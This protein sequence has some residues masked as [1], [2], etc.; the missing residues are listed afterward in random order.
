[1][2]TAEPSAQSSDKRHQRPETHLIV[3]AADVHRNAIPDPR[4]QPPRRPDTGAARR[5]VSPR[6]AAIR[7]GGCGGGPQAPGPGSVAG[8]AGEDNQRQW[9]SLEVARVGGLQERSTRRVKSY[10][11]RLLVTQFLNDPLRITEFL[12][13]PCN[14]TDEYAVSI[15]EESLAAKPAAGVLRAE[16]LTR[17]LFGDEPSRILPRHGSKAPPSDVMSQGLGGER[18]LV[19]KISGDLRSAVAQDLNIGAVMQHSQ[20]ASAAKNETTVYVE[21]LVQQPNIQSRRMKFGIA[22]ANR[23]SKPQAAV[24]AATVAGAKTDNSFDS[25]AT[26]FDRSSSSHNEVRTKWFL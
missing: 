25:V 14:E 21:N 24:P 4:V 1:M 17:S 26:D 5:P 10:E 9:S 19:L 22:G 6:L 16:S 20:P 18:D 13:G 2:L 15:V 7:R 8:G 3:T 12:N 23:D 11:E